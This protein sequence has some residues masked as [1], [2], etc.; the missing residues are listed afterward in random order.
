MID[1]C[2]EEDK[3]CLA[4]VDEQYEPCETKYVKEWTEYVN[5]GASK[6]D[7]LLDSYMAKLFSCVV[8]KDGDSYFSYNPD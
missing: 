5:A 6:E 4:A 2:G 8:D 7:A 3:A 1:I